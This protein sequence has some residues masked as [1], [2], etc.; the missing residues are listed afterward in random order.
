MPV[1][2]SQAINEAVNCTGAVE[3]SIKQMK[4]LRGVR[5]HPAC[6]SESRHGTSSQ[7]PTFRRVLTGYH[8]YQLSYSIRLL[9]SQTINTFELIKRLL[10]MTVSHKT[11]IVK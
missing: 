1:L 9:I 2:L 10:K 4:W 11:Y 6:L 7:I 8:R 3:E 5:N